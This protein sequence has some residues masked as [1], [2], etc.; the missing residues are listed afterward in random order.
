M[1]ETVIRQGRHNGYQWLTSTEHYSGTLLRVC[2]EV[3]I[4]RYLAITCV[5][6]GSRSIHDIDNVAGWEIRNG[7]GYSPKLDH[8]TDIP[9]QIDGPDGPGYDEFYIFESPRDLGERVQGNI[10]LEPFAP[11]P[12]RTAVFVSWAAF[13]LYGS[14]DIVDLFWPQFERLHPESFIADGSACLT[15]VTRNNLLF[16]LVRERLAASLVP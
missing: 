11:A 8:V 6:G 13:V 12:G 4:D 3:F 10:F 14:N 9:H 16:E 15:F 7:I 2:P 1:D 5:D